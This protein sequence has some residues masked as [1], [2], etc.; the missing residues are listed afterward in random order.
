MVMVSQELPV[1]YIFA[2]PFVKENIFAERFEA[3]SQE[4]LKPHGGNIYEE[5]NFMK[6]IFLNRFLM[7]FM[8]DSVTI[9]T[10]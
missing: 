8:K 10:A 4:G 6:A 2:S 7:H 5:K 9:A 1:T 3:S